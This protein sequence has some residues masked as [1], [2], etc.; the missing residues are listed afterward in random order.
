LASYWPD[1]KNKILLLEDMEAPLSR[2]ERSLRQL[3]FIGVFDQISGLIVGKPEFYNQ[4]GAPFDYNDIFK[5]VLGPR[6]YPIVSNFDCSHCVPMISIPQLTPVHLRAL[7]S[8][9]VTF[10]FLNGGIE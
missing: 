2:T 9:K 10:S 5:E 1:F 3:N 6:K 8:T 4:E 7:N